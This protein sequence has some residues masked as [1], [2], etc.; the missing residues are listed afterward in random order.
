MQPPRDRIDYD[1]LRSFADRAPG[2]GRVDAHVDEEPSQR[3]R[4]PRRGSG[5]LDRIVIGTAYAIQWLRSRVSSK[6]AGRS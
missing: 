1:A 4:G 2:H 5:I 6:H 3:Q